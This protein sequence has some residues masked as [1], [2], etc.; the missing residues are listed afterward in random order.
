MSLLDPAHGRQAALHTVARL[1]WRSASRTP[2]VIAVCAAAVAVVVEAWHYTHGTPYP[3]RLGMVPISPSVVPVVVLIAVCGGRFVG[4]ARSRGSARVFWAM[5]VGVIA[6]VTL[7]VD[8]IGPLSSAGLVLAA[9]SEELVYRVA[10]PLVVAFGLARLGT[11]YR[12][13]L[14]VGYVVAGISFVLLP[15]HVGQMSGA[16]HVAPF[17]AFTILATLAVHRSGAILEIGLLHSAV[18]IVNVGRMT[19]A[20]GTGGALLVGALLGLLVIGYIPASRRREPDVLID[21]TGDDPTVVVDGRPG[22][23]GDGAAAPA[24]LQSEALR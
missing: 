3:I 8:G 4:R 20:I 9:Y 7:A 17:I 5:V 14:T 23:A 2:A 18:N 13:A 22:P 12:H 19:G 6:A 15:G 1:G 24:R 21:L 11:P 16:A 10:G